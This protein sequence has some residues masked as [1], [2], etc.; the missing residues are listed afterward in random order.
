MNYTV[1]SDHILGESHKKLNM[2]CEDYSGHY[3]D[4]QQRY[5]IAVICDGHSDNQC[6]RSAVGARFG[7]ESLIEVMRN[8]MELYCA[9]EESEQEQIWYHQS[10]IKQRIRM[11]FVHTWNEKVK[12]DIAEHPITEEELAPLDTARTRSTLKQYRENKLLST[13]Y[14]ATMLAVCVCDRF[15][16]AMQIGDGAIVKLEQGGVYTVP[17]EEDDKPEMEGPESMCDSD[18]LSREKAFRIEIAPGNPQAM[19]VMS[20]GVGDT[21]LSL[22]LRSNLQTLQ[23]NLVE[24]MKENPQEGSEINETQAQFLHS[25]L[26]YYCS[27]GLQD[28]CSIG[29]FYNPAIEVSE[30]WLSKEELDAMKQNLEREKKERE[31]KY[32]DTK[33][34]L[35]EA[36]D[37]NKRKIQDLERKK[38]MLQKQLGEI[39]EQLG[40]EN[41]RN[42]QIEN[43]MQANE[44]DYENAMKAQ[45]AARSSLEKYDRME[46]P[47]AA[48]KKIGAD[49]SRIDDS[50]TDESK[51]DD[52]K[53]DELKQDKEF[54]PFKETDAVK[55]QAETTT[56]N[57]MADTSENDSQ[58]QEGAV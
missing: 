54:I 5:A 37:E 14:G 36:Y 1:F 11:A 9:A 18:L 28:D 6:F 44:R 56:T 29:G 13:I 23:K 26:E 15:H 46:K 34:K 55:D 27:Q 10:E 16:M 20:D 43:S 52:S 21:P 4:P 40:G 47:E 32:L 8:W 49:K 39:E 19:F 50:K 38:E 57:D 33:Q 24:K 31:R 42:V 35:L 53:T 25:F 45:S 51:L 30:V 41:G 7:C 3:A 22:G 12:K 58:N 17:V 48:V 2:G